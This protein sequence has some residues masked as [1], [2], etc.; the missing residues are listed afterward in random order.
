MSTF[1]SRIWSRPELRVAVVFVCTMIAVTA[2]VVFQTGLHQ[3]QQLLSAYQIRLGYVTHTRDAILR[4]QF[5]QLARDVRFLSATPPVS[6]IVRAS[7]HGGVDPQENSTMAAWHSRL[8]S[9]FSAFLAAN[10][11]FSSVRFIGIAN[12]GK[13]L[14]RVERNAQDQVEVTPAAKLQAHGD[15]DYMQETIRLETGQVYFSDINL[16]SRHRDAGGNTAVPTIRVATPIRDAGGKTFGIVIINFDA[17]NLLA[18]LFQSIPVELKLYVTNQGGDYLAQP[19][20]SRVFGFEKNLQWRWSDD[21]QPTT[22]L[23]GQPEGLQAYSSPHGTAYVRSINIPFNPA[24]PNHYCTVYAVLPDEA[25]AGMVATTRRATL[26]TSLGIFLL[27][28]AVASL[29]LRKYRQAS[30]RQAELAAIVESSHDAIIGCT[31]DG[32]VSSWNAGAE[33]MFLYPAAETLSRK[34]TELIV[35]PEIE[36]LLR[37]LRQD[38]VQNSFNS[39]LHTREGLLLDVAI[40]MSPIQSRD[41]RLSGFALTIRDITDQK[42]TEKRIR[43]LNASLEQQVEAR[44]AQIRIYSALQNAI[45]A[46]AGYAIIATDLSGMI[47]LFNPA[48][49]R[50]L[51]YRADEMIGRQP[52]TRLH[53]QSELAAQ[54]ASLS[55]ELSEDIQAGFD[56]IVARSRHGLSNESQW[57]YARRDGRLFPVQLT[58]S[59]LENEAGEASGYLGIAADITEREQDRR[60]LESARDQLEKAAEVAELGIWRWEINSD[61]L[62]WNDR[63]FEIYDI[64]KSFRVFGLYYNHWRSR[65]HPDDIAMAEHKLQGALEGSD[66]YNPTFRIVRQDGEIR[67]LQAAALIEYEADGKPGRVLGINRDITSQ[68]EQEDWLLEAKAAADSAN[69]AKSEFLANMSHEIRTPMNAILGMLQLLQQTGLDNRQADYTDKAATA[70]RTLL[71]ILNDILDFSRVEAGKLTLDPHPFSIDKLL[72]DIGVI[73][74][75]NVGDKDV[76][77]LFD[78]DPALPDEIV[79]D[80]L[81]L[82]QILI[83]LSGNAIKFTER[84]EVVLSAR[85]QQQDE[86]RLTIAFAIRDTGIGISAEQC[87]RIFE[88]FSQAETSTA[89]RYGGS[90]LG[91][92]ISQ[93]LVSLMGGQL[94]VASEQGQ[95]STFSFTIECETAQPPPLA[96]PAGIVSLHNL[97]CLVIEDND[98]ARQ[99][100]SAILRSFGW[101]VDVAGSGEEALAMVAEGRDYNIVLIDWKMPGMDG[102]ETCSRLRAM[103]SG[104]HTPVIMMVTA[105][106]RELFAQRQQRDPDLFDS[107]LVKPVTAS[108]LFDAVADAQASHGEPAPT[109]IRPANLAPRLSGLRL[110]LVEDNPTNQQVA[111]E[112]L[113]HEGAEVAVADCGQAALQ[114][115]HDAAPLYDL[116][117]MDIQ[118]P[119]MDGYTVTRRIRADHPAD[120]LPIIAMTANVMPADREAALEAGMNDHVG[121]PFDLAQLVEVIQRHTGR[122][123]APPPAPPPQPRP[124]DGKQ[125]L[126][127]QSA[128]PRFGGN[129]Q[130]YRHTLLSFCD[131]IHSLL[132]DLEDARASQRRD[133]AVQALHTLKGLA[134]TVGAEELAALA[135][136]EEKTMR[137]PEQRWPDNPEPLRQAAQRAEAAAQE[138]AERLPHGAAPAARADTDAEDLHI[139]LASLRHMLNTAN[140]EAMHVFEQLRQQHYHAMPG[141]F[142]QLSDAIMKMNFAAAARLC[143]DILQ[144]A[145]VDQ[146]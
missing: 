95:G 57:T 68:R 140:L 1:R 100:Q 87:Q 137:A 44:T 79:A 94:S 71:A 117:L 23:L 30:A 83:N 8:A 4:N 21:F 126:N 11:E 124:A 69:R 81:R 92:A 125:T 54:A 119:D 72:R 62:E 40:T 22:P 84:G 102:W 27:I 52:L 109:P 144:R 13:E 25:V 31:P 17:R 73:L 7:A 59:T 123:A 46:N 19:D 26:A 56:A 49:E 111:R 139:G 113:G 35:P 116:V 110:L 45:L 134:A 136:A 80:A 118:M 41:N 105:Y 132:R 58:V 12:D 142:D 145:K 86:N 20:P 38:G 70:A 93:R 2:A 106:G 63:M 146:P 66:V 104:R 51:G 28:G 16:G 9:I 103:Q 141:E 143:A 114:A 10:P 53:R 55:Q 61:T 5:D 47:T 75:A 77:I 112:L 67:Y 3:R 122:P 6:G 78:I 60:A 74:S 48:A 135:A 32:T 15:R 99:T 98:T 33:K 107:M 96:P 50:M 89:R 120:Q 39:S 88:G 91:L 42:A 127:S 97:S 131:E 90:G 29:Y 130:I 18:S 85:L 108:M 36:P 24:F 115:V 128:I 101:Q 138:E 65:V 37:E 76:E 82:Q 43:E 34:L 129:L 121:K 14:A 64:P 133:K